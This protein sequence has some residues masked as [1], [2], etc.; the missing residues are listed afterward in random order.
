MHDM[1]LFTEYKYYLYSQIY[2]KKLNVT[3]NHR[4]KLKENMNFEKQETIFNL[5]TRKFQK[6]ENAI[7]YSC[8]GSY[9]WKSICSY[10]QNFITDSEKTTK[11]LKIQAKTMQG[12][13]NTINLFLI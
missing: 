11:P 2:A 1:A 5:K 9:T 3:R 7:Y 8:Y 4:G 6:S 10:G 12:S 13:V